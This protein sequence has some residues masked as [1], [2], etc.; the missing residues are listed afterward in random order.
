[1]TSLEAIWD[2]MIPDKTESV[3]FFVLMNSATAHRHLSSAFFMAYIWN[4]IRYSQT[5]TT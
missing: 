2:N 3:H 1:M 5:G 4:P